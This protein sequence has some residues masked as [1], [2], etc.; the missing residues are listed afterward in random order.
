MVSIWRDR[1]ITLTPVNFLVKPLPGMGMVGRMN[2]INRASIREK[3]CQGWL[4]PERQLRFI[5]T[6]RRCATMPPLRRKGTETFAARLRSFTKALIRSTG[7][8]AEKR[9]RA[10]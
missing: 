1:A 10:G 7:K 5:I 2:P 4:I 6:V 3:M 9:R 8:R